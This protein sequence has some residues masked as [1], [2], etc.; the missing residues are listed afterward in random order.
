M[1]QEKCS[2]LKAIHGVFLLNNENCVLQDKFRK[3]ES[4]LQRKE[5]DCGVKY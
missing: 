3:Y 1:F 4:T 2:S 5:I